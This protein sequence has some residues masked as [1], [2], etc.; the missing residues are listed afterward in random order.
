MISIYTLL[1]KCTYVL[2]VLVLTLWVHREPAFLYTFTLLEDFKDAPE[3][4]TTYNTEYRTEDF[5]VG[6]E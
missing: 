2:F 4:R 6:E 5:I 3:T 1:K